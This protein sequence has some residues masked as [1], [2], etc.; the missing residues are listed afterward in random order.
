MPDWS[1]RSSQWLDCTPVLG[2]CDAVLAAADRSAPLSFS[3]SSSSI[4]S[5][6]AIPSG[7]NWKCI[8]CRARGWS[9]EK[10]AAQL[11]KMWLRWGLQGL[12]PLQ[13]HQLAHTVSFSSLYV[14]WR[15]PCVLLPHILLSSNSSLFACLSSQIPPFIFGLLSLLFFVSLFCSWLDMHMVL[16]QCKLCHLV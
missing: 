15:L 14:F 13:H 6:S 1:Q 8:S 2:H 16:F 4:P 10:E 3:S 12:A 9:G 11:M 7:F 5:S